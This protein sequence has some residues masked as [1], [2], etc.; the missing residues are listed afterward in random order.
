MKNTFGNNVSVT[1]FGESHGDSIG[2]VIDGLTPGIDVDLDF[3]NSQL[4]RRRPRGKISTQRV[5]KDEFKIVSGVFEGKTSGTPLCVIIPNE[6]T[7][8]KDYSQTI[9]LPRPSHADYSAQC[10][11]H[12]FQD[13]R[14]GGH[15]SGRLTAP[16]V[17]VG[18][19]AI[20]A[21]SQK[22]ICIGTHVKRCAKISDRDFSDI[23]EDI[24]YL[25]GK[26]FSVLDEKSEEKMKEAIEIAAK[27]GDS[28]GGILETAIVGIP[29]GIGEPW[30]D[31]L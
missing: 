10:K 7:N 20:S 12:G 26:N 29:A 6:N 31:S 3:I 24:K 25:Q 30:F 15:F 18:A 17:A 13:Y 4:Q 5:E 11:Y 27:D 8:S 16:L 2:A 1:I 9:N 22:G 21:L 28:V 19:I 14:G 23:Y